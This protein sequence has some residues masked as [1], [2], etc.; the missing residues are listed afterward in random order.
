MR[1]CS[2]EQR[3]VSVGDSEGTVCLENNP[4]G[5]LHS[6]HIDVRCHFIQNEMK[7]GRVDVKHEKTGK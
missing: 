7:E 3:V 6:N 1:P 2:V 5:F 4:L